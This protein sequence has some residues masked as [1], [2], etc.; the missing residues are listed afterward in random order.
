PG[1]AGHVVRPIP[2][3]IGDR[4]GAQE[5]DRQVGP[6]ELGEGSR[7]VPDAGRRERQQGPG[8]EE[9]SGNR[10]GSHASPNLSGGRSAASGWG[11]GEPTKNHSRAGKAGWQEATAAA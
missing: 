8:K 3:E 4:D 11:R 7:G 10:G 2:V 5:S 6:G 9:Q 1:G